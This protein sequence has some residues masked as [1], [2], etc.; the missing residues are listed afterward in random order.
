MCRK[1]SFPALGWAKI[2]EERD[3][4]IGILEKYHLESTLAAVCCQDRSELQEVSPLHASMPHELHDCEAVFEVNVEPR[5]SELPKHQ[6]TTTIH[7]E[8]TS[9]E[10]ASH[11]TDVCVVPLHS[12]MLRAPEGSH[13]VG[14]HCPLP[15]SQAPASTN[16]L[17]LQSRQQ[18]VEKG[19]E[20]R[21]W[22]ILTAYELTCFYFPET[23]RLTTLFPSPS[24]HLNLNQRS[25]LSAPPALSQAIRFINPLLSSPSLASAG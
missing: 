13:R 20:N 7:S 15:N 16:Q 1:H 22:I 4:S 12:L 25:Q 3:I 5:A 23:C 18:K 19:M 21:G 9:P 17:P 8:E 2:H 6:T 10:P 24:F 11:K 14:Q